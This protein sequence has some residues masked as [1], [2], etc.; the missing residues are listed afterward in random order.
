[1]SEPLLKVLTA[2]ATREGLALC[3]GPFARRTG[4]RIE[5]DTTHGHLIERQV[6]AGE[7]DHDMVLLP[8][9][10][11]DTLAG[12]GLVV[13]A[14]CVS[15]GRIRV[16]AAVR[17][18]AAAPDV[19]TMD[20]LKETLAGAGS[21]VLTTAPSGR[22][23]ERVIA[24]LGLMDALAGRIVRYDTGA[25][26]NDHLIASGAA[27]EVAFGVATE[28]SVYRDRGVTYAG[29]IPDAVQMALDYDAAL[30][31][32]SERRTEAAALLAFLASRAGR[33]AFART[34]VENQSLS[35]TRRTP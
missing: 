25:M 9:A 7:A 31:A 28:I 27:G 17:D 3:A 24:G 13:E 6:R 30:L 10:M 23:M 12:L 16:G 26:V 21:I 35:S 18:G 5:A 19:S 20:A 15:L 11:I 1:M 2:G 14:L 32:R 33:T 4:I 34:G 8:S 29:P 22:H